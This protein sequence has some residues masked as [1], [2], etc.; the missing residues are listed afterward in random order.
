MSRFC[1]CVFF[2]MDTHR[3]DMLSMYP[4]YQIETFSFYIGGWFFREFSTLYKTKRTHTH[5]Q[6]KRNFCLCYFCVF[7]FIFTKKKKKICL[8]LPLYFYYML[9]LFSGPFWLIHAPHTHAHTCYPFAWIHL[10]VCVCGNL[11]WKYKKILKNLF[12]G[13]CRVSILFKRFEVFSSIF[14]SCL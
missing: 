5:G 4:E 12:F 13:F 8:D 6:K 11:L 3:K 14:E 2:Y 7:L 9:F 10:C 1:L